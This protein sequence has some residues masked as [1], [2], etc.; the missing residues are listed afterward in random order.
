MG[1]SRSRT[2]D[3]N[4]DFLMRLIGCPPDPGIQPTCRILVGIPSAAIHRHL[5]DFLR[6]AGIQVDDYTEAKQIIEATADLLGI[7]RSF[8]DHSMWRFMSSGKKN[9]KQKPC[10]SKG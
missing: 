3:L 5:I 1:I 7:H 9:D 4:L 10:Q 6:R 8:L 2:K